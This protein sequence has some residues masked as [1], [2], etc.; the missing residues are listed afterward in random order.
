M[1]ILGSSSPRRAEIISYFDIPFQQ[2]ASPFNENSVPYLGDPE[3]YVQLI[4][5]GK[6]E[7][8]VD[9]YPTQPILTADTIVYKKGRVYTKPRT[10][11]EGFETLS[12]LVGKEH[13]VYTGVALC[14]GSESWYEVAATKVV[15][16]PLTGEQIRRYQEAIHCADKAGGY[17]VQ[18]GGSLIIER[19]EGCFYNVMG[20]P[21][22]SVQRLLLHVGIDLWDHIAAC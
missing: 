15:M 1:L 19:V 8:L 20:L 7:A 14:L 17:A 6:G 16:H 21:I 9:A 13:T 11:Q 18:Q 2:V 4:A 10:N 5:R 3:E 12:A 22:Q